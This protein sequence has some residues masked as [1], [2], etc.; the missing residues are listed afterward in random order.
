MHALIDQI[1]EKYKD[2]GLP[3]DAAIERMAH[4]Y[5]KA[6]AEY[7]RLN[8][9]EVPDG[10]P[11]RSEWANKFTAAYAVVSGTRDALGKALNRRE[12]AGK[13]VPASFGKRL[14][15]SREDFGP[16][17]DSGVTEERRRELLSPSRGGLDVL[18]AE[19]KAALE[20]GRKAG[21][22]YQKKAL[23]ARGLS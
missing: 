22:A 15:L 17:A 6:K 18:D 1:D 9:A 4:D 19:S 3:D 21:E 16:E 20:H 11:G 12:A 13:P 8:N 2:A 10:K 14:E 7:A 5:D 23:A